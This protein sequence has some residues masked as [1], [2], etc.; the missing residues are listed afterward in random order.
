VPWNEAECLLTHGSN[1]FTLCRPRTQIS[2]GS[3][4]TSMDSDHIP[5]VVIGIWR[6]TVLR[7]LRPL[8]Q[9]LPNSKKVGVTGIEA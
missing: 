9:K 5:H 3:T 7:V 8:C 1:M 2:T 4:S 6:L